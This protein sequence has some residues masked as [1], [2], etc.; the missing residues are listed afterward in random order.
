MP[1]AILHDTSNIFQ[2]CWPVPDA[3]IFTEAKMPGSI[4]ARVWHRDYVKWVLCWSI[5]GESSEHV[6]VWD[7]RFGECSFLLTPGGLQ[8]SMNL[9]Y[10]CFWSG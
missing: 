3:R 1:T 6:C 7:S 10:A 9:T 8:S 2:P 4:Q 5:A